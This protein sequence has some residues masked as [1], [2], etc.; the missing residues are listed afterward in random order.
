[1]KLIVFLT[2]LLS[3]FTTQNKNI[4]GAAHLRLIF[5]K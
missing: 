5:G 4:R 3:D 2:K 1:M